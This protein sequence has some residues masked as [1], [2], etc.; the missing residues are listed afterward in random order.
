MSNEGKS[1]KQLSIYERQQVLKHGLLLEEFLKNGEMP[2]EYFTGKV[3]FAGLILE[4][5]QQVLIPRV[6]TEELVDHALTILKK[7][8][9]KTLKVIDLAT[10][11]GAIALALINQLSLINFL[12]K[13]WE[14]YLIDISEAAISLAKKNYQ[15]L[16]SKHNFQNQVK[17]NF[18]ISDL[19]EKVDSN[20]RGDLLLANLPYIPSKKIQKLPASVRLYEP[21]IALDGGKTGFDLIVKALNQVIENNLLAKNAILLFETDSSHDEQFVNSNFPFLLKKF[22]FK[23]IKDQFNRPRFLQL[24]KL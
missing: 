16:V 22:K 6:E 3:D 21:L 12:N 18:I 8:Q 19:F 7:K 23:F 10:G 1:A 17:V 5:N 2:V 20:L 11:S 9:E 14:F 24:K 4:V 13:K 15:N